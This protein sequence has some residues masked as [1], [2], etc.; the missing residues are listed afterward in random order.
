M[1]AAN[2]TLEKLDANYRRRTG[3]RVA[4]AVLMMAAACAALAQKQAQQPG[5]PDRKSVV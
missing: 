2:M 4:G 1:G 5:G 3:L